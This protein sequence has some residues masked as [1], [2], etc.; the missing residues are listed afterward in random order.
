VPAP[1]PK[2][3]NLVRSA[4]RWIEP[5]CPALW[6]RLHILRLRYSILAYKRRRV[7][8]TFGAFPLIIELRDPLGAG[9]YDRDWPELPEFRFLDE[10]GRLA[11][12]R[13]FDLGAHQGVVAIIL[14]RYVGRG[15]SVL[16]VEANV[17][18]ADAA[19]CNAELNHAENCTILHGAVAEKSGPISFTE[20]LNGSINNT[21]NGSIVQV[22]GYSIDDLADRYGMPD[23]IFIDV[24]GYE[25]RTLRGAARVLANRPDVLIEVH[26][27]HR[28]DR[29]GGSTEE[30]LAHFPASDYSL[31]FN[32][33]HG[34]EFRPI[35]GELPQERFFVIALANTR[36]S[37]AARP[38]LAG[39]PPQDPGRRAVDPGEHATAI[40]NRF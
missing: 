13:V 35:M 29:F 33:E 21:G 23:L 11:K 24:E 20:S 28:L 1:V 26:L 8:H 37:G 3:N 15:G 38:V 9:W 36:I 5:A 22:A 18:N 17:H 16:A 14:S 4:K 32:E 34:A 6:A 19:R 7:T 12:A 30:L 2:Q 27:G 10:H 25:C 40:V 31:Y 39:E